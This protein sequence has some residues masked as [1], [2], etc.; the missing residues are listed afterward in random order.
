[1]TGLARVARPTSSQ[2]LRRLLDTPDL[3]AQISALPPAALGRLIDRVGLADAGEIVALATTEQ[4]V[5]VFDEDLW[6]S[7]RIGEDER[8]DAERFVVWLEILLE[9]GESFVAGRLLE[10]PED[11]VTLA[12]HRAILVLR[13]DALLAEMRESDE[14]EVLE[15]EKALD[16]CLY[17]ELDEFQLVAR[18]HEGWDAVLTSL[19]ALDQEDHGFAARLLER[20]AQM[21]ATEIED[22]GGLHEILTSGDTLEADV[23][24]ER[25][26]RRA[27]AGH[28]T[29]SAAT[30]FLELART[31]KRPLDGER[32]PMT[33]AWF[34]ELGRGSP[35]PEAPISPRLGAAVAEA[36][37]DEEARPRVLSLGSAPGPG[38]EAAP[39]EDRLSHAM[40]ALAR[41]DAT[42]FALRSDELAYVV[43]VLLAGTALAEAGGARKLRPIEAVRVAIAVSCRGLESAF[44][45]KDD[46]NEVLRRFSIDRLFS[47]GWKLLHDEV[48]ERGHAAA[49]ADAERRSVGEAL[50][51]DVVAALRRS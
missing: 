33:R 28:V 22:A 4:L 34:R 9:A 48:R 45:E 36:I 12:F 46:P 14:D 39:L 21:S 29:P 23:A 40:R 16:D 10:L 49:R 30:A 43:N 26:D 24:G 17:E 35:G 2:L 38:R 1:V 6:K 19:L 44:V 18:H 3:P 27:E 41:T 13:L 50:A 51:T 8:F 25:E 47:F 15:I 7:D 31:A 20:C 5:H 37:A 11:L 32:D 42:C